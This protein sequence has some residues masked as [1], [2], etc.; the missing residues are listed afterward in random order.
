MKIVRLLF[1][2]AVLVGGLVVGAANSQV[3]TLSLV[4]WQIE[5]TSGIAIISSLLLGA[6]VGGGLVA[7][8]VV[9]PLYSKLRRAQKLAQPSTVEAA[10]APVASSPFDGR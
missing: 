7:A 4:L 6:I 5:T 9:I 8:A 2:L 1:L 3:I 10:S